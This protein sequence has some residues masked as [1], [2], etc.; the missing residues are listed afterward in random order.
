MSLFG[1]C[2]LEMKVISNVPV[3][4]ENVNYYN[5]FDE[6][7]VSDVG[8]NIFVLTYA[9]VIGIMKSCLYLSDNM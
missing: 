5:D 8:S 3:L 1:E 7:F 4:F 9:V 6:A 2:G